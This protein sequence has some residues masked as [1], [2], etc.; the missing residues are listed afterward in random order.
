M[1]YPVSELCTLFFF[2]LVGRGPLSRF[3]NTDA[4]VQDE[5]RR[6]TYNPSLAHSSDL[7]VTSE[8][9]SKQLVPVGFI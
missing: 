3:F 4:V 9:E 5:N 2:V 6:A 7:F 8:G 1:W